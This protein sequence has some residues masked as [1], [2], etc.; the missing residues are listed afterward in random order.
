V[1]IYEYS[2]SCHIWHLWDQKV[3]GYSSFAD[4]KTLYM[5]IVVS[6][7][8]MVRPNYS[9]TLL[10]SLSRDQRIRDSLRRKTY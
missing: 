1:Q 7:N 6:S 2:K 9:R 10:R 5:H 8:L 4:N 3:A